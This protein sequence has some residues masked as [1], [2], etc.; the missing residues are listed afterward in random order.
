MYA[1]HLCSSHLMRLVKI[2]L[3]TLGLRDLRAANCATAAHILSQLGDVRSLYTSST[4]GPV[5]STT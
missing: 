5:E 3:T 4:G 1:Q 2:E